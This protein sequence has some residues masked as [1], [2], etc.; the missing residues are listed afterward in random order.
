MKINNKAF[1]LLGILILLSF[2]WNCSIYRDSKA[3]EREEEKTRQ[4]IVDIARK[5]EGTKYR[6]AGKT[7]RGFDCS[8]FTRYVF[9]KEDI[10]LDASA[11][12]QSRQGRYKEL[13]DVEPGDLVFFGPPFKIDHVG[14][15]TQNKKGNLT[16]IHSTN[17]Q[18]VVEEDV[19]QIL[20]WKKRIKFARDV[21][22][23]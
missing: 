12:M 19:F 16:I 1:S 5:Y 3:R 23:P 10:A 6:R 11:K 7:P 17:S 4:E 18:G 15:V 14:I 9:K 20:Y 8:G 13:D 21:I 2:F 22:S